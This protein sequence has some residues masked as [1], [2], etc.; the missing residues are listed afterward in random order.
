MVMKIGDHG[1]WGGDE[2][3]GQLA[4]AGCPRD[5]LQRHV[6]KYARVSQ[7]IPLANTKSQHKSLATR[8]DVL[9]DKFFS[10]YGYLRNATRPRARLIEASFGK[11]QLVTKTLGH[12]TVGVS[13]GAIFCG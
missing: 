3:P 5:G 1:I 8:T 10:Q 9:R 4:E 6:C 13:T 7:Q 11:L 2:A 12:R